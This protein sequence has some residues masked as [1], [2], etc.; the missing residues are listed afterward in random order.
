MFGGILGGNGKMWLDDLKITIDGKD[1]QQLKPYIPKPFP[2]DEDKTFDTG[3]HLVFPE[4][5]QQHIRDLELLGRIWGFLK[6]HHPAIAGGNYNWDYELFRFLPDYLKTNGYEQRDHLLLGW[7]DKLGNIPVC[8]NCQPASESVFLNPDLSWIEH[9]IISRDLKS[10]LQHIYQNRHQVNHYYIMM[11]YFGNPLFLNENEYANMPYPDAGFRLLALYRYWNMVYYFFPSRYMTDKDWNDVLG[12]YIPCFMDAGNELEYELIA[13]RM[14]EE[15]C[16]SHASN[17]LGGGDK[18]DFLRGYRM[19]P[20]KTR[21]IENK[22]VV[23]DYYTLRNNTLTNDEVEKTTG[24]HIGDVITHINGKSVHSIMDSIRIYYPA[25]NEATRMKN[26]ALDIFRANQDTIRID[27]ITSGGYAKQ[28]DIHLFYLY[29]LNLYERDTA[30]CYKFL[31]K[32]QHLGYITLETIRDED[33]PVI[34]KEFLNAK[35]LII[36]IRNYPGS[37]VGPLLGAYFVSTVTPFAKYTKGNPRNPGEFSF[38]EPELIYPGKEIYQGKVVVI[39]D[40]NTQS[41]GEFEAMAFRAGNN[42]TI[43]GSTTAGSD[44]R[45]SNIF[46]PGGIKTWISGKGVY[47]LDGRETQRV[48]IVPDIEVKPTITGITEGRDELLEKAIEIIEKE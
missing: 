7:I 25:S 23:T 6:Y 43:I 16:D 26:I 33:L 13:T 19:P 11:G 39:V 31:D 27:Y 14:I 30:A 3:S 29:Y 9:G 4:L 5:S 20:F 42:T 21:F 40:E 48:G 18:I 37:P 45:V 8:E 24:L 15:I 17:L 47:Y 22:L 2:A 36:D 28:K 12:E 10:K 44:G 32:D 46:L 1:V 34:K 41:E 35:G 38:S